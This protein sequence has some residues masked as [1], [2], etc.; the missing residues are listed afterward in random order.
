M[1]H[2]MQSIAIEF[3]KAMSWGRAAT[4]QMIFSDQYTVRRQ[5]LV[6]ELFGYKL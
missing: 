3:W 5:V 6:F 2:P 1:N 4:V